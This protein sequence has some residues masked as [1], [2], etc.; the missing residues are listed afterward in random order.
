MLRND[1]DLRSQGAY[2]QVANIFAVESNAPGLHVVKS[3]YQIDQS[4]LADAAHADQC[5]HLTRFDGHIDI[6]E[7]RRLAIGEMD[8]VESDPLRETLRVAGAGLVLNLRYFIQYFENPLGPR[9]TLMNRSVGSSQ[10]LERLIHEKHR[11]H[12][13]HELAL[14]AAAGDNAPTAIPDH[15]AD[16]EGSEQL[17]RRRND[18]FDST[19]AQG[20]FEQPPIFNREALIFIVFHAEG[21]DDAITLNTLLKQGGKGA[22]ADLAALGDAFYFSAHAHHRQYRSGKNDERDAR[23]HPL[24]KKRHRDQDH[25][26]D[27]VFHKGRHRVGDGIAQQADIAVDAR[28]QSSRRMPVKK[29]HREGLEMAVQRVAHIIDDAQP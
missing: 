11:G 21:L 10:P 16:T 5:D 7:H 20:L 3:G 6:L 27:R 17:H 8:I 25:E 12:E 28:H 14:R 13:G 15:A 1:A 18:R 29:R 19:G 24:F 4:A 2:R 26:R 23:Q 22:G 9:Q